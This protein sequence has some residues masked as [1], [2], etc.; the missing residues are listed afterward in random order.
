MSKPLSLEDFDL[1]LAKPELAIPSKH[2]KATSVMLPSSFPEA[3]LFAL[4]KSLFGRPRGFMSLALG[5]KNPEGLRGDPDAPFKY[6]FSVELPDHSYL[7]IVLSWL[8]LEVR[9]FGVIPT[10]AQ[11]LCRFTCTFDLH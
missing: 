11:S 5:Y 9:R 4:L 7:S 3:R 8:N 6:E 2:G 1:S 10:L